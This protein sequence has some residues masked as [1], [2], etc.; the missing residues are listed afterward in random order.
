M[1]AGEKGGN[2]SRCVAGGTWGGG[3]CMVAEM[4]Q[5]RSVMLVMSAR[6][7]MASVSQPAVGSRGTASVLG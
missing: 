3:A 4:L 7:A 1:A 6:P 2:G 5:D